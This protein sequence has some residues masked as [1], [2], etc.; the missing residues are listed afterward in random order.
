MPLNRQVAEMV[1]ANDLASIQAGGGPVVPPSRREID[2][3]AMFNRHF[4]DWYWGHYLDDARTAL[5]Q[6]SELLRT[7]LAKEPIHGR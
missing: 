4:V 2:D 3:R 6:V 1:R 5:R 7:E